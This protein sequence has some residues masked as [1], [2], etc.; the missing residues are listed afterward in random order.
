MSPGP[1]GM[2]SRHGLWGFSD[3]WGAPA[4]SVGPEAWHL[5]RREGE[6]LGD[7][8]RAAQSLPE[9]S[10]QGLPR[11]HSELSGMGG[12]VW[13]RTVHGCQPVV[14]AHAA[15]GPGTEVRGGSSQL[16]GKTGLC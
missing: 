4:P 15:I 7:G 12:G 11:R 14:L 9:S 16:S 6:D 2:R 8:G 13:G 5:R 1:E 3:P 10:G